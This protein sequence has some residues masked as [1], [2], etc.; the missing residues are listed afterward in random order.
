MYNGHTIQENEDPGSFGMA[1]DQTFELQQFHFHSP[2]EHTVDGKHLPM[3]MHLV[4]MAKNGTVAVIGVFVR[5]GAHNHSFDRLWSLLPDQLTPKIDLEQ[6]IDT[7]SLLPE[8]RDYYYYDGSFTTP[9]CTE[10]VK[11]LVLKQPV[12]LS[13]AQ[14]ERFRKVINHNNRPVQPL[15]G[16]KILVSQNQKRLQ[17]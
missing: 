12:N 7:E 3:E 4:H 14:I 9:P 16:R 17:N 2:S 11:W 1:G 15:N 13:K 6:K 8:S 5:E 10:K